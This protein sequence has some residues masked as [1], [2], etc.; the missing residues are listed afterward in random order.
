[1]ICRLCRDGSHAHVGRCANDAGVRE[2]CR[3]GIWRA[4]VPFAVDVALAAAVAGI[5]V[6]LLAWLP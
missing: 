2:R 4:W 6:A 1:M 5:V 3:C